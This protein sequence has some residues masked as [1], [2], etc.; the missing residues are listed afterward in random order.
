MASARAEKRRRQVREWKEREARD[1]RARRGLRRQR[2]RRGGGKVGLEEGAGETE[3]G[4]EGGVKGEEG[5]RK[6]VRFS[7]VMEV[8]VG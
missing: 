5:A 7:D 1:A 8:E 3:E 2:N 6:E 4:V